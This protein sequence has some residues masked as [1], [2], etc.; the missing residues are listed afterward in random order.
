MKCERR[1]IPVDQVRSI[2]ASYAG[3]F[4][5]ASSHR[6]QAAIHRRY[7]WLKSFL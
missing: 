5:H 1:R 2:W 3:H 6:V 7:R 4:R